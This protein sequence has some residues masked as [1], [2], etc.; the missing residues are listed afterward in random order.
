MDFL[1]QA[2]RKDGTVDRVVAAFAASPR[3]SMVY[4][5]TGT[6]KAAVI[7]ACYHAH[8]RPTVVVT[9]GRDAVTEL[10]ADLRA[11]LPAAA[12]LELPPLDI[13]TFTAAARSIELAAVRMDVLGRLARGEQVIV[14]AGAE[15]AMQKVLPREDFLAGRLTVTVGETLGRDDLLAALVRF[16]YERTDQVDSRGQFSVRGGI[17]DVF[18]VNR[19]L[20]LR[21][22]L[23]GDEVDSLRE[24]DPATQRSLDNL[25]HADVLPLA[26][27]EHASKSAA[28]LSYLSVGTSVVFDEPTRIREQIG[29]LTKENPDIKP[30]VFAWADLAAA[31]KAFNVLFFSLMLQRIPHAEPAEIVSVTARGVP[32]FHRQMDMLV[33]ELKGWQARE[34]ATVVFMAAREKAVALQKSLAAEGVRAIFAAAPATL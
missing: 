4:G 21:L 12:V 31:A 16:G 29:R 7:A 8:P 25:P 9:A 6:Q 32:P 24:F 22:E 2:M 1:L 17:V 34:R 19:A 23:W 28:F 27:P 10:A 20:P 11:L 5:V 13:V 33:D 26:E 30:Q 3:Q 14:L 18:P 15:A